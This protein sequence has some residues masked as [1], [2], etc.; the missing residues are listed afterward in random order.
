MRAWLA[1]ALVVAC[2]DA[3]PCD[4][5]TGACVTVHVESQSIAE[6]DQL[7]L[8]VTYGATH[9]TA[10]T[11]GAAVLPVVTAIVIDTTTSITVGVVAAGKLSGTVLG[12]GAASMTIDPAQHGAIHLQLAAPDV[13]V[14]GSFYCG[15]DKVA[16]DPQTLYQCNG[17]GVPLSRGVC[18]G[19]CVLRPTLDDACRGV[20]GTCTDGALYCG[21]DKLDGDPQTLYRCTA[22]VGTQGMRCAN[23]CVV[24]PGQNDGCR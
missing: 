6:I 10:T 21:G 7:E 1:L 5:I 2:T 9:G 14:A 19:G 15:G 4:G 11:S 24:R 12:T 16:G 3:D 18:A 17:G 13:C 22:A 20:G 23:G 8:D